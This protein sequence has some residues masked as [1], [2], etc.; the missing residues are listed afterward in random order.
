MNSCKK[1]TET[2]RMYSSLGGVWE[3]G[4]GGGGK[5][6]EKK[7]EKKKKLMLVGGGC[8]RRSL[9]CAPPSAPPL[10]LLKIF[11]IISA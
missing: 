8:G 10:P 6:K 4:G 1:S 9:P 11:S 5:K 2:L 3:G 7:E